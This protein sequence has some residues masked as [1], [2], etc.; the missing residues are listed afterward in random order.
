[1]GCLMGCLYYVKK[2]SLQYPINT[3]IYKQTI[4]INIVEYP[5]INRNIF[6]T[7]LNLLIYSKFI[8]YECVLN[9]LP[10]QLRLFYLNEHLLVRGVGCG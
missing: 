1:M 4:K 10:M 3:L 7:I 2:A 9:L 8:S 6:K 5:L